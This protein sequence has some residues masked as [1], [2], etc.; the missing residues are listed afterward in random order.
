MLSGRNDN[1]DYNTAH[2]SG[3]ALANGSS[4]YFDM[5]AYHTRGSS[6]NVSTEDE[7]TFFGGF[8]V[9]KT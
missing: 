5:T 1:K 4:D 7:L 6:L 2:V 3:I 8:L 9:K